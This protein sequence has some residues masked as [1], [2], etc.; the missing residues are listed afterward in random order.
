V[1]IIG[2]PEKTGGDSERHIEGRG[3]I[4]HRGR[5][6]LVAFAREVNAIRYFYLDRI[7]SLKLTKLHFKPDPKFSIREHTL[8]PLSVSI[9]EPSQVSLELNPEGA[10]S[11]VDFLAGLPANKYSMKGTTIKLRTSNRQALFNFMIGHPGSVRS[12]GPENELREFKE[13]IS[14]I[15]ALYKD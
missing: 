15:R 9:H 3:L 1:M 10:D 12:L 8:H 5:W 2:Y 4:S 14:K 6:C 7:K 11:V 13:Y